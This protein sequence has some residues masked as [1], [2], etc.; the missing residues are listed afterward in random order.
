MKTKLIY[1]VLFVALAFIVIGCDGGDS[2]TKPDYPIEVPFTEY[3]V[4]GT[5]CQW[6]WGSLNSYRGELI[7]INSDDELKNYI[8]CTDDSYPDVD[9]SKS[10]ILLANGGTPRLINTIEKRLQQI[11][12]N[13]YKLNV[14]VGLLDATQPYA[15]AVALITNKLSEISHIEL[16]VTIVPEEPGDTTVEEPDYPI[17]TPFTEYLLAGT[18]CQWPWKTYSNYFDTKIFVINSNDELKNYITCTDG[19]YPD[20]DFSKNSMLLAGGIASQLVQGIETQLQ[21]ISANEYKLN[22][23]IALSDAM[24]PERWDVA[25]LTSKWSK[26][27]DVELDLTITWGNS[28]VWMESVK[29][30]RVKE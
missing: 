30:E 25:L 14:V 9:F 4:T 17:E 1:F 18:S 22:V 21:Q 11:S 13:E 28:V 7:I 24:Q 20:V 15:W 5:P 2:P 16:G 12:E 19:S 23:V 26:R 10:S 29:Y 27:S 6:R 3:L 8:T